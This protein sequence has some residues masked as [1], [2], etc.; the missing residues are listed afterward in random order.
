GCAGKAC[1]LLGLTCD[2]GCFCRPDGV[3][4]VAGVCV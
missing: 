2:A 4:I 3:G 1:N